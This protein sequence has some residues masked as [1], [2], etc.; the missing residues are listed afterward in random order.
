MAEGQASG[1]SLLVYPGNADTSGQKK[2]H[3]PWILPN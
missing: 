1:V 2:V 3:D